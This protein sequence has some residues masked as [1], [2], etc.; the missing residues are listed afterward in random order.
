LLDLA[1]PP[2][3]P[4]HTAIG[5]LPFNYFSLLLSG[6]QA[7]GVAITASIEV[8]GGDITNDSKKMCLLYLFLFR[9]PIAYIRFTDKKKKIL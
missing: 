3:Q 6:W 4:P 2:S 8:N 9:G 5:Q 1:P 7:D